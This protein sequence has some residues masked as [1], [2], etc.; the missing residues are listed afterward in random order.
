MY[1]FINNN[2]VLEEARLKKL[3]DKRLAEEELVRLGEEEKNL[4][5]WKNEYESVLE[6]SLTE[7]TNNEDWYKY[8]FCEEG[9]IN[10]RREKDLNSFLYDFKERCDAVYLLYII[11]EFYFDKISF[12]RKE[13]QRRN[14]KF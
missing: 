5:P 11:I 7:M 10:V 12:D 14:D 2:I 4:V 8:S 9:Y 6:N 13:F 1:Y 3:D